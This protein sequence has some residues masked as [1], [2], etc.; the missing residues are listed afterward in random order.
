MGRGTKSHDCLDLGAGN[1][2]LLGL[3]LYPCGHQYPLARRDHADRRFVVSCRL[4]ARGHQAAMTAK[5]ETISVRTRGKGTYEITGEVAR[6]VRESGVHTGTVTVFIRHTSASLVIYENADPSARTDLHDYFE[7]RPRGWRLRSHA[8]RAG[9]HDKPSAH[10]PYPDKRGDTHRR[11]TND[12]RNLAGDL[13]LRTSTRHA[14]QAGGCR[15]SGRLTSSLAEWN[16]PDLMH[17]QFPRPRVP[18]ACSSRVPIERLQLA[19]HFSNQRRPARLMAG[20]DA[21]AIVAV[22]VFVE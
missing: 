1:S 22:E 9:R 20:S 19:D 12:T 8:R 5:H 15:R 18:L 13:C 11:W 7:N 14:Y 2:H 3:A 10:G 16:E 4:A 6:A 21:S 17:D